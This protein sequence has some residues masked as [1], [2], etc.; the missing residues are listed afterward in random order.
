MEDKLREIR[1]EVPEDYRQEVQEMIDK[2]ESIIG[3]EMEPLRLKKEFEEVEQKLLKLEEKIKKQEGKNK[4]LLSKI[5]SAKHEVI[6]LIVF[7]CAADDLDK[8][9]L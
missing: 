4:E 2:M 8:M 3:K 7:C 6:M 9:G 1:E 5:S